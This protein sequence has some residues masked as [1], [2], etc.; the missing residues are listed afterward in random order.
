MSNSVTRY[1][2]NLNKKKMQ[3]REND[4]RVGGLTGDDGL[5]L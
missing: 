3:I 2:Y 5:S 1:I 4:G